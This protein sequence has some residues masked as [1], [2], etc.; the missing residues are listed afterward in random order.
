[1]AK[2]VAIS[3]ALPSGVDGGRF[4]VRVVRDGTF[5]EL[6]VVWLGLIDKRGTAAHPLEKSNLGKPVSSFFILTS[7]DSRII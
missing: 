3:I 4:I 1:M 7:L 2:R 5:L 6:T